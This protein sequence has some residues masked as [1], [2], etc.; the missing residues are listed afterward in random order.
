MRDVQPDG[1][2][3]RVEGFVVPIT[4]ATRPPEAD[5][6]LLVPPGESLAMGESLFLVATETT[7]QMIYSA[8]ET[9]LRGPLLWSPVEAEDPLIAAHE[10]VDRHNEGVR[11]AQRWH[12][13]GL[14]FWVAMAALFLMMALSGN[15]GWGWVCLPATFLGLAVLE[16]AAGEED[17]IARIPD[18]IEAGALAFRFGG[19]HAAPMTDGRWRRGTAAQVRRSKIWN[20]R[21]A[22]RLGAVCVILSGA[23]FPLSHPVVGVC[24][25]IVAAACLP[26]VVLN[27]D[28]ERYPA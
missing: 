5:E 4:G 27:R 6:W 12:W 16:W 1:S 13:A 7:P 10:V 26:V 23:A 25:A 8:G 20:K 21:A 9:V 14:S 19:A 11:S 18:A 3:G 28:A 15:A 17:E 22:G 24:V 2:E